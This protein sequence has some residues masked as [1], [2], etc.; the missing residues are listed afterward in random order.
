MTSR[1]NSPDMAPAAGTPR[2]AAPPSGRWNLEQ[3]RTRWPLIAAVG[4]AGVAALFAVRGF[5]PSDDR[6]A[7]ERRWRE[8]QDAVTA[9][10]DTGRPADAVSA[11]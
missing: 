6:R 10:I 9:G 1:R 7:I 4:C 11:A 2:N 8:L 5:S 3:R